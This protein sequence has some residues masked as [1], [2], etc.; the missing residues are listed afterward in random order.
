M[1]APTDQTDDLRR[2][3]ALPPALAA[4]REAFPRDAW[5]TNPNFGGLVSFW[6]DRHL[7][8]RQFMAT[9]RTDAQALADTRVAP[10]VFG[11]RF[12]RMG[13]AFLGELDGH[14]RIED[15]HYFP[16][17]AALEPRISRGFEM[18]DRDHH[19]LEEM[20]HAFAENAN[21]ALQLVAEGGPAADAA[22]G[23]LGA[24]DALERPLDRH[25]LDEEDIVVPI[26]LRHGEGRLA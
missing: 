19:A 10:E 16:A 22:G 9:M 15:A 6:L 12:A 20:L 18:L 24:L 17:L 14:H 2:R 13:S 11:Q 1:T 5:Q 3:T 26:I 25:L 4:L 8:F 21:R 23:V 7:M